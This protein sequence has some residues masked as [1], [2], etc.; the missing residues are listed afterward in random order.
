MKRLYRSRD[1]RVI[2]GVCGG[3]GKYFNMDP[4]VFRVIMILLVFGFGTGI[5][6]YLIAFLIIPPEPIN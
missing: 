1:D 4:V 2:F 6:F 5:L 3:F